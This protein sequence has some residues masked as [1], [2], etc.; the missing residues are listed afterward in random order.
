MKSNYTILSLALVLPSLGLVFY[1][2]SDNPGKEFGQGVQ[3]VS[4]NRTAPTSTHR[5]D[6]FETP[7]GSVNDAVPQ[8]SDGTPVI[9]VS[10]Q[11][12]GAQAPRSGFT[13]P[14][15]APVANSNPTGT[16]A[17]SNGAR[18]GVLPRAI[19]SPQSP[20]ILQPPPPNLTPQQLAKYQ[21]LQ[22]QFIQ[23]AG[24]NNPNQVPSNP[25]SVKRWQDAQS[26][27][28]Q[29]YQLWFGSQAY[30]NLQMQRALQQQKQ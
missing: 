19:Q 7:A 23:Q 28:D 24:S 25:A 14:Y 8:Y 16:G 30:M 17:A 18:A 13:S 27:S 22:Q 15:G 1:L 26:K 10:N 20:M 4:R 29:L 2:L 21:D 11:E 9:S 3:P 5:V 6:G 12:S